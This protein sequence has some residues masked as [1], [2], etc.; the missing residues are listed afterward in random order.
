MWGLTWASGVLL[1]LSA[2]CS[3]VMCRACPETLLTWPS[4]SLSMIY[5]CAQWLWPQTCVQCQSRWLLD[6]VGKFLPIQSWV[7]SLGFLVR[8]EL[9]CVLSFRQP[10][11]RYQ[12][13]DCLLASTVCRLRMCVPLC[14]MW[15]C[16]KCHMASSFLPLSRTT[17]TAI[18]SSSNF[19]VATFTQH[20]ASHPTSGSLLTTSS[21][22]PSLLT[23]TSLQDQKELKPLLALLLISIRDAFLTTYSLLP[24]HMSEDSHHEYFKL[25]LLIRSS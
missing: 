6:L 1:M 21:P 7:W 18:C 12:I 4:L 2:E 17:T 15:A 9:L 8:T 13:Y 24:S 5:C 19:L 23:V 11:P 14:C 16:G 10:W 22:L 25:S 20:L 3:A